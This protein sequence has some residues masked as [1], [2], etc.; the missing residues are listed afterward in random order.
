MIELVETMKY[1]RQGK[2]LASTL[3]MKNYDQGQLVILPFPSPL[4]LAVVVPNNFLGRALGAT[5]PPVLV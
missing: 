3:G 5:Y 2:V 1:L 4:A